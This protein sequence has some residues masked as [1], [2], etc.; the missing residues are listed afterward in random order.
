MQEQNDANPLLSIQFRVPFDRIRVA[1]VEP[2][3]GE[4][5]AQARASLAAIAGEPGE[6]TFANTMLALDVMTEPLDYAMG[7]VRHLETVATTPDRKS[8][9]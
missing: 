6:R 2:A 8:V 4:L 9:V 3:I 5:L 7:V 1:D